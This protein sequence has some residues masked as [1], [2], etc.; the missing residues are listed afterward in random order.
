MMLKGTLAQLVLQGVKCQTCHKQTQMLLW[1]HACVC[2]ACACMC[3]RACV[4]VYWALHTEIS[5]LGH[6]GWSKFTKNLSAVP[7]LHATRLT[8]G[9]CPFVSHSPRAPASPFSG[10]PFPSSL[11][12]SWE[13]QHLRTRMA[14]AWGKHS[15]SL[16][17][18][19]TAGAGEGVVLASA[20]VPQEANHQRT[21]EARL[22]AD[23]MWKNSFWGLLWEPTWHR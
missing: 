4:C 23:C 14:A 22:R 17:R 9:A 3:V 1:R 5:L 13:D 7:T 10:A 18:A 19:F 8:S 20:A 15:I 16:W 2:G 21:A 6:Y 11:P 12:P